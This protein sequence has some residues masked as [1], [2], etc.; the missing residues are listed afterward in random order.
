MKTEL[1]KANKKETIRQ[2]K[3]KAIVVS[4]LKSREIRLKGK[5]KKRSRPYTKETQKKAAK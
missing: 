4:R 2:V 5:N 1:S 3:N